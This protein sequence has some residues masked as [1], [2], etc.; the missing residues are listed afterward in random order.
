M[1]TLP[2]TTRIG[3]SETALPLKEIVK[4][5]KDTYC[6]NIGVEYMFINDRAKCKFKKWWS[7]LIKNVC[8]RVCNGVHISV[9]HVPLALRC[10]T[11]LTELS[12]HCMCESFG[13][14]HRL[15]YMYLDRDYWLIQLLVF[16]EGG[17]RYRVPIFSTVLRTCSVFSVYTSEVLGRWNEPQWQWEIP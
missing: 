13:I 7:A 17:I 4:R 8:I 11:S 6:N 14:P 9:I 3:G 1:F 5:L 15:L 16:Q 12:T 2:K 10:A